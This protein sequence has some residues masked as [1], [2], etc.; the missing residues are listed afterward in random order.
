MAAYSGKTGTVDTAGNAHLKVTRWSMNRTCAEVETSGM[1]DAGIRRFVPGMRGATVSFDANYDD[2]GVT[3]RPPDIT[4]DAVMTWQLET[5]GA[6]ARTFSGNCVVSD[7]TY[8][9][10]FED[11]I[12]YSVEA[13][14][15][16]DVTEV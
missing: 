9:T 6:A 10:D 1:S 12:A 13:T 4:T 11:K 8:N 7:Y 5:D 14:V 16:G 3:G 15:D 2:T